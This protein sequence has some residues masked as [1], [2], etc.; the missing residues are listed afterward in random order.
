MRARA[1]WHLKRK[2]Y[3]C[4]Q[5]HESALIASRLAADVAAR[6]AANASVIVTNMQL[7][8]FAV[9]ALAAVIALV[10][11]VIQLCSR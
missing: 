10:L 4:Q 5:K 8:A 7:R 11:L 6:A 3:A 9:A 2:Q 1:D